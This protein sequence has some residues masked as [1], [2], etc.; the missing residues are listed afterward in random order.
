[1]AKNSIAGM[2]RKA[3]R[4]WFDYVLTIAIAARCQSSS[5]PSFTPSN[6]NVER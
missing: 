6:R 3:D 2:T 4:G 1:M 5:D